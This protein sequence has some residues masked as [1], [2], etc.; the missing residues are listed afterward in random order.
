MRFEDHICGVANN[1]IHYLLRKA[2][3]CATAQAD[4]VIMQYLKQASTH[5]ESAAPG[6][7]FE[8]VSLHKKKTCYLVMLFKDYICVVVNSKKH[9]LL[10]N[11]CY[12]QQPN[13]MQSS[14]RALDE[15]RI[16]QVCGAKD[17]IQACFDA[18]ENTCFPCHAL[19]GLHLRHRQQNSL[20]AQENVLSETAQLDAVIIQS[21]E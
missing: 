17:R 20:P 8:P 18:E 2:L 12:L 9:C 3:L 7:E 13:W 1:V 16:P 4:A 10:R 11:M 6:T 5:H 21:L 19:Q 15:Q 14:F